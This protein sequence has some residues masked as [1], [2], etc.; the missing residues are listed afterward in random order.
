M[1]LLEQL[2]GCDWGRVLWTPDDT[3]PCPERA[4]R[5]ICLHNPHRVPNQPDGLEVKL[6]TW[7]AT[8]VCEEETESSKAVEDA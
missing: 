6:C 5:R 3:E 4:T 1:G 7:H 2:L 8:R